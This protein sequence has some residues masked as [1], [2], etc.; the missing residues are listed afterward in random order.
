MNSVPLA[1]RCLAYVEWMNSSSFTAGFC[2]AFIIL[3]LHSLFS[4]FFSFFSR[5][6]SPFSIHSYT[7]IRK[8]MG[9]CLQLESDGCCGIF[10]FFFFYYFF[11]SFAE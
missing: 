5:V 6:L 9:R 4:A 8:E 1:T 10:V 2:G 3:L 7:A 11:T